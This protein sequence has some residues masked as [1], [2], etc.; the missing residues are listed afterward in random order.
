[1][2][3]ESFSLQ[4]EANS[5]KKKKKPTDAL[6]HAESH[7]ECKQIIGCESGSP[8][9]GETCGRKEGRTNRPK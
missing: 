3:L 8:Q 6:L 1:M 5:E 9:K 4:G 7:L 2:D